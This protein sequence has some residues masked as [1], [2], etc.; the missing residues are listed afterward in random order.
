MKEMTIKLNEILLKDKTSGET[1]TV[2]TV[3]T[4]N[5]L[6]GFIEEREKEEAQWK[7]E[8]AL[9]DLYGSGKEER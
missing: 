9:A 5:E 8:S 3:L 2:Q 6:A 7:V 4:L 1:R